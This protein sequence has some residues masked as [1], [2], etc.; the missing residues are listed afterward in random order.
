MSIFPKDFP[1]VTLSEE[2]KIV[3]DTFEEY[4][5]RNMPAYRERWEKDGVFPRNLMKEV[6]GIF[7]DSFI[8]EN[9]G[10]KLDETTMGILSEIM[11]RYGVPVPVFLTMHFAKLLPYINDVNVK[12]RYIEKFKRG[13]LVI[14][15]AFSEPGCGSD[16]AGIKTEAASGA[17]GLTVTGEKSFVS[18]PGLSDAFIIS[19]R[20]EP[21]PEGQQHKGIS[22]MILDANTKGVEPYSTDSMASE[23]PGDFGGVNFS[24]AKIPEGNLIGEPGRGF[25][26]LM[27]ILNV[28]RVHV[29]LYSLGIAED[30]LEEAIEY[31]KIRKTFGNPIG[32]YQAI[33]F[34][35]AENWTRLE[36]SRLLSYRALE[37]SRGTEN[38]STYCAAVKWYACENAFRAVDESLQTLGASGYVKSSAMESRFR[39]SRG[40]LIGD[41]TPDIQ[42]L[43]I[44]RNL[45]GR[46]YSP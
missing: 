1:Y 15:G 37:I 14:C 30:G 8:S 40:F 36:A 12:E 11:G 41:G 22:L 2:Q 44:A 6:A 26:L 23:F 21:F 7:Q 3:L 33:S 43:I 18:S 5:A 19:A 13:D 42:K 35:I 39:M 4:C 28:Q 32:K 17:D 27:N 16:S 29:S 46:E 38:G 20:T 9:P 31:S 34:R 25:Y 10:E 45:L 24:S